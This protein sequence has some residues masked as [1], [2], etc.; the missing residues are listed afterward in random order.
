LSSH[1][2]IVT[3]TGSSDGYSLSVPNRSQYGIHSVRSARCL[4]WSLGGARDVTRNGQPCMRGTLSQLHHL[5]V[6]SALSQPRQLLALSD[7]GHSDEPPSPSTWWMNRRTGISMPCLSKHS[8]G[9]SS[10]QPHPNWLCN[11][12]SPV[13]IVVSRNLYRLLDA[14]CSCAFLTPRI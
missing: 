10:M 7:V 5:Q 4:S 14:S 9:Q 13:L 8:T 3:C 12:S 1:I 11:F 6:Y 2:H